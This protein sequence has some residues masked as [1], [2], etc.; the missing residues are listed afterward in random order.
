MGKRPGKKP[1]KRPGNGEQPSKG[2]GMGGDIGT[3]W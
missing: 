2:A 3:G 1:G